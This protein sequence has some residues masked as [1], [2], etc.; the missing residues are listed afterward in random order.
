[1]MEV[2]TCTVNE[3]ISEMWSVTEQYLE[4]H[5]KQVTS[6]VWRRD[7][8]HNWES[9][10]CV[11]WRALVGIPSIHLKPGM[12]VCA[13]AVASETSFW[14]SERLC[15]TKWKEIKEETKSHHPLVSWLYMLG[16]T[17]LPTAFEGKASLVPKCVCLRLMALSW[18]YCLSEYWIWKLLIYCFI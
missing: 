3:Q 13:A 5:G 8:A 15:L 4:A 18:N 16:C 11:S 10:C 12:T 9:A 7:W 6:N 1:M 17:Y 14:Y 2:D